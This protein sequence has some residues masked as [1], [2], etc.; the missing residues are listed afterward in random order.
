MSPLKKPRI[1]RKYWTISGSFKPYISRMDSRYSSLVPPL[2]D[3]P[4]NKVMGSPGMN[5]TIRNTMIDTRINVGINC[6]IL[7]AIYLSILFLPQFAI[8]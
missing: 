5:R 2:S 7:L 3:T 6:N 8:I 4:Y 1:Q